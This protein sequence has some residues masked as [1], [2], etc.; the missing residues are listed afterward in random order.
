MTSQIENTFHFMRRSESGKF[1][2]TFSRKHNHHSA[3]PKTTHS[4]PWGPTTT[5]SGLWVPDANETHEWN[6]GRQTLL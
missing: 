1:L 2:A 3:G 5:H 6:Q 4:G